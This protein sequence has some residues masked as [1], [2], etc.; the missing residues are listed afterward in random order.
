MSERKIELVFFE[1]CPNAAQARE[2]LN[3]ALL[4]SGKPPTWHE[5]DVGSSATPEEYR[6]YGSPT[7]LIDGRDVTGPSGESQAMACR[8]DGAPSVAAI[9]EKLG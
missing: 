9:L 3:A 5:W 7:V 4:T 8:A 2:N 6:V 1:G